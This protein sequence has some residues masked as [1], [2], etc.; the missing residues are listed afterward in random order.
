MV[1]LQKSLWPSHQTLTLSNAVKGNRFAAHSFSSWASA[2]SIRNAYIS[3]SFPNRNLPLKAF[4]VRITNKSH[5]F[6]I[7][8]PFDRLAVP[9]AAEIATD[10]QTSDSCFKFIH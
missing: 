6:E 4:T 5:W 9:N 7:V 10:T 2:F 1:A 8:L 3:T